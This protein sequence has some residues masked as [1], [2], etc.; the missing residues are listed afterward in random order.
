MHHALMSEQL[1]GPVN[2]TA[3]ASV[4][5]DEFAA[6]LGRVLRRPAMLPVP[7]AALRL[8]FG[9]MADVALLGSQRVV[10]ARLAEAAYDFRFPSLEGALRHVLGKP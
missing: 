6:T 2:V 5:W 7:A 3:P 4:R 1:S 8:A 10:P 9:E